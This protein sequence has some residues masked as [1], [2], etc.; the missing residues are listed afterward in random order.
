ML[1]VVD[2][3]IL[4][5]VYSTNDLSNRLPDHAPRAWKHTMPTVKI[6]FY[7][8]ITF[9]ISYTVLSRIRVYSLDDVPQVSG[10]IQ[11]QQPI[12]N[13]YFVERRSF[14]VTEER[15]RNPDLVPAAALFQ[16]CYPPR[17]VRNL[18]STAAGAAVKRVDYISS[19]LFSPSR[20]SLSFLCI[21][22]YCSRSSRQFCLRYILTA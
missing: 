19:Q 15:V 9:S 16:L 2:Y 12:I 8:Y 20:R 17:R 21:G 14:L 6:T 18:T 1:I 4:F 5:L 3:F 7:C 22:L 13:G 10:C 11:P